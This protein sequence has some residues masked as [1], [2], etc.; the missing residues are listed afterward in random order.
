MAIKLKVGKDSVSGTCEGV[1]EAVESKFDP[2]APGAVEVAKFRVAR[3]L[4]KLAV[5]SKEDGD[6]FEA[7]AKEG[8]PG[9]V[10]VAEG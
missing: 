8:K 1:S 2:K 6:A 10:P 7:A 9:H 5:R 4:S 3:Q